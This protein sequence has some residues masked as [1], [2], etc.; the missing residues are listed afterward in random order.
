M[1]GV[2]IQKELENVY[3][4]FQNKILSK[5][6]EEQVSVYY[7]R[8]RIVKKDTFEETEQQTFKK[9]FMSRILDKPT[10]FWI[11]GCGNGEIA[12]EISKFLEIDAYEDNKVESNDMYITQDENAIISIINR[13]IMLY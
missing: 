7:T 4:E 11:I 6:K 10:V 3:E 5:Y 8:S 9:E 12:S 2:E 13:I 1:F